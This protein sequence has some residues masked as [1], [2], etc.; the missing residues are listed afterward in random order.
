[1]GFTGL[2]SREMGYAIPHGRK[3]GVL[4]PGAMSA[5]GKFDWPQFARNQYKAPSTLRHAIMV[6]HYDIVRVPVFQCVEQFDKFVKW[7][8]R[9]AI[10][11]AFWNVFNEQILRPES[12][13]ESVEF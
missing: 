1:M 7:A 3:S 12:S 2:Y 11:V 4:R 8:V 10:T 6:R 5:L 9:L 13:H